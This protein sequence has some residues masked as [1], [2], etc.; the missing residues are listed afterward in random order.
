MTA[1]PPSDPLPTFTSLDLTLSRDQGTLHSSFGAGSEAQS[2]SH[3]AA[4]NHDKIA[5]RIISQSSAS[6]ALSPDNLPQAPKDLLLSPALSAIAIEGFDSASSSAANSGSSTPT[7]TGTHTPA[8]VPEPSSTSATAG[9]SR[10]STP[11]SFPMVAPGNTSQGSFATTAGSKSASS[12]GTTAT[13]SSKSVFG[14]LFERSNASTSSVSTGGGGSVGEK[15]ER[16]ESS[17]SGSANGTTGGA[18]LARKTSKKET[19]KA[20]K[21]RLKV[22]KERLKAE[23]KEREKEEKLLRVPSSAKR[24]TSQDGRK[25]SE[26]SVS[27]NSGSN[28]D[29]SQSRPRAPSHGEKEKDNGMGAALNEFMRNKVSRKSSVTSKRSD[30]GRSDKGSEKDGHSGYGGSDAGKSSLTKK[31]GVCEKIAIGKGATA[32]VKLA[33][34]WDRTTERLYAVKVCPIFVSFLSVRGG[35]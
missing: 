18:A 12:N 17:N 20:E 30:D 32:T 1:T 21:E 5:H 23:E 28:G 10:V 14:K 33:H 3:V 31:Y 34:K 7:G 15:M 35:Y 26:S 13:K 4:T 27:V 6:H 11:S 24:T 16:G 29:A 22:E 19:E 2:L 9:S 8:L 25:R